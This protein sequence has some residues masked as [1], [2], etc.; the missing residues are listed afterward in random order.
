MSKTYYKVHFLASLF[1]AIEAR[2]PDHN[3]TIR[4][5]VKLLKNIKKQAEEKK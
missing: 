1:L 3:F 4:D 5:I 2:D